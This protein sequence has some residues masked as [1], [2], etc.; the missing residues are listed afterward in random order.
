MRLSLAASVRNLDFLN[1]WRP[2]L[3]LERAEPPQQ[4]APYSP[5]S[6]P[7]Q[8][9]TALVAGR[10][11]TRAENC[12]TAGDGPEQAAPLGLGAGVFFKVLEPAAMN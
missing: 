4:K 3:A 11:A 7:V 1:H 8:V 6:P 5:Y 2:A 12:W 10:L 9:A